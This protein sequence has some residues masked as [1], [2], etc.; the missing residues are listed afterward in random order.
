MGQLIVASA[1]CTAAGNRLVSSDSQFMAPYQAPI[2]Q[3]IQKQS[4]MNIG[5]IVE[6][7]R[8]TVCK[9]EDHFRAGIAPASP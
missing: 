3:R 4:R 8:V 5:Q 6:A 9:V 1:E 2:E 7:Q